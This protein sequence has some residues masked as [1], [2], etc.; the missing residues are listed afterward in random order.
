MGVKT[1]MAEGV[2]GAILGMSGGFEACI[3]KGGYK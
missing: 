3:M 1:W 2:E